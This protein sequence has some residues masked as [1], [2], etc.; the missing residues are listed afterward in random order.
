MFLGFVFILAL[1]ITGVFSARVSYSAKYE[2]GLGGKS[3]H[4]SRLGSI[5]DNHVDTLI[6]NIGR[7][8]NGRY[9]AKHSRH[10]MVLMR[11]VREVKTEGQ[12]NQEVQDMI[13]L[14]CQKLPECGS[15]SPAE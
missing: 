6:L 11:P 10:S 2:H 12:A 3:G 9:T 4:T 5:E 14:V 1:L 8:S 13:H 15:T 7:W